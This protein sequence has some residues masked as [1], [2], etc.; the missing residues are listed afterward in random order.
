M[1]ITETID[2]KLTFL[3]C[4]TSKSIEQI[5]NTVKA[6]I[7][8]HVVFDFNACFGSSKSNTIFRA[9]F[10]CELSS[11]VEEI[12]VVLLHLNWQ[13]IGLASLQLKGKV[14]EIF[15]SLWTKAIGLVNSATY[16][17]TEC[18]CLMYSTFSL[19][20]LDVTNTTGLARWSSTVKGGPN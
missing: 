15:L 6:L 4:F 11:I 19:W 8:S 20:S 1:W 9:N 12:L 3:L 14:V 16:V 13:I 18:V 5:R 7:I 2:V 17:R 10:G